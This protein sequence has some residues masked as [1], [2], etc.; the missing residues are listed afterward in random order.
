[1]H[2]RRGGG[3]EVHLAEPFKISVTVDA[4]HKTRVYIGVADGE[5]FSDFKENIRHVVDGVFTVGRYAS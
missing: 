1:M 2:G 5:H 3:N 4:G